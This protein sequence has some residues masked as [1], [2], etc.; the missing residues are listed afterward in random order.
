MSVGELAIR[1]RTALVAASRSSASSRSRFSCLFSRASL[2]PAPLREMLRFFDGGRLVAGI[3]YPFWIFD[4][5]F[6]I[7]TIIT[8]AHSDFVLRY[9]SCALASLRSF[10]FAQDLLCRNIPYFVFP[11]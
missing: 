4:F 1:R 8:L 5:G 11:S 3:N 2:A 7:E 9:S 6:W 10:D